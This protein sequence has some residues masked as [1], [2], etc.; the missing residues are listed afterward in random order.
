MNI[1]FAISA[2]RM[3]I[4]ISSSA[5]S[6]RL[7]ASQE[8][9]FNEKELGAWASTGVK[10]LCAQSENAR[11]NTTVSR[12]KMRKGVENAIECLPGVS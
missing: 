12:A 5:W 11:G 7:Q 4:F 9:R 10:T 8:M 6:E 1:N 2:T 3:L